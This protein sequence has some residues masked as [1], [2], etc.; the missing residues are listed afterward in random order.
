MNRL[1]AL[2]P[3]H[4]ISDDLCLPPNSSQCSLQV[5]YSTSMSLQWE[6]QKTPSSVI[7][8]FSVAYAITIA[9]S[10]ASC[11][12]LVKR[13]VLLEPVASLSS[14]SCLISSR[15]DNVRTKV[16]VACCGVLS[17]SLAV[18]SGFGVLLLLGQ[19]FVMTAASCPFMILGGWT[20]DSNM[21]H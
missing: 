21:Y 17:T 11:W 1:T 16:W 18:L 12:R 15:S 2:V 5:S 20:K 14:F 9:F 13:L 4:D 19:S 7:P 10:V 6:F 3:I 8:L